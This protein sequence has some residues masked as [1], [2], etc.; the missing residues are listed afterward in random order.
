MKQRIG[1]V[2]MWA[3]IA[4][5][6]LPAPLPHAKW[7]FYKRL[8]APSIAKF[9]P[10]V[11]VELT[12][13]EN[14]VQALFAN[15]YLAT[16][17]LNEQTNESSKY[18]GPITQDNEHIDPRLLKDLDGP[19]KGYAISKMLVVAGKYYQVTVYNTDSYAMLEVETTLPAI[20]FQ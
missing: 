5:Q 16:W 19:Q 20:I 1:I 17:E 10:I 3:L 9:I 4:T 11:F 13:N 2:I 8:N 7:R 6:C 18:T 14:K 12:K 15:K